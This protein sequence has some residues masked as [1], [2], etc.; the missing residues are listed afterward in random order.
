MSN[1]AIYKPPVK[2]VRPMLASS[3]RSLLAHFSGPREL[4]ALWHI[5]SNLRPARSDRPV[6]KSTHT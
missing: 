1:V 5:L 4:N 3:G 2:H 6:Y